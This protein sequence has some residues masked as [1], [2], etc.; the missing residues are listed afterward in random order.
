MDL[1]AIIWFQEAK[2]TGVF[3]DWESFVL[4]LHVRFGS[5]AYDDPMEGPG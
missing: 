4:A 5:G 1:E 2:E 3:S